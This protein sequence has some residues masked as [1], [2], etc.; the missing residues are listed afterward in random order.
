MGLPRHIHIDTALEEE[1]VVRSALESAT[2]T[3]LSDE[4]LARLH[5]VLY[6]VFCVTYS[7]ADDGF[8]VRN[9]TGN[10]DTILVDGLWT[11][12]D[13]E[14]APYTEAASDPQRV[15]VRDYD[16]GL[17]HDGPGTTVALD[18]QTTN[19]HAGS[20]LPDRVERYCADN[21][22]GEG[23]AAELKR[24]FDFPQDIDFDSFEDVVS[25]TRTYLPFWL[26]EFH[27]GDE[28][29]ATLR[30]FRTLE[31]IRDNS[32]R[33]QWLAAFISEDP[34]RLATYGHRIASADASE[35]LDDQSHR[36]TSTERTESAEGPERSADDQPQSS[37]DSS[38]EREEDASDDSGP[39]QPEGAELQADQLLE[40][41]PERGF[42][43]VGGMDDL[44]DALEQKVIDPLERPEAY[45]EYGIGTVTGV[46]L[47][48]PPGCG[49][50]YI[51]GALAGEIGYNVVELDPADLT[52]RYMGQ[53]AKNVEDAFAVARANQPCVVFIDEIDAIAGSRDGEMNTSE[54]QMVNQLLTELEAV[55][56]ED[57]VVIAATN[58]VEDI[59]DAIRRSGRFDERIEVPPPGADARREI[60][61]LYLDERPVVD[62]IDLDEVVSKTAGYAAS[63][64]EHL[65]NEAARK[66][67]HD[68]EDIAAE[69][70]LAA[71]EENTTSIPDWTGE[72][73]T[74]VLDITEPSGVDLNAHHLLEPNPDRD[75]ADVGGMGDL[76]DTLRE[77]VIH[78]LENAEDYAEY[79][80]GVTDGVLLH[81][82]PGCGKTYVAGA[83]AGELGHAF[84]PVS[85]ADVTSKWM[86]RPAKNV[87]DL[88]TIARA[89]AP[90]VLFID[91]IDAIAGSRGGEM[92]TSEQQMVNQLLTELEG[93][94][95]DGV[96]V[97]AAT[98]LIEDVDDAILRSGRFDERIE[99]PAPDE[100]ARR[101]ILELH[102][103][104]RP[105]AEDIEWDAIVWKTAGYAASDLA[106][107]AEHA[108]REALREGSVV[109]TDHL[110]EAVQSTESSIEQWV[111][112]DAENGGT[113][114]SEDS[115]AGNRYIR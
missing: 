30:S 17:N 83:L 54:Q 25:V 70:L 63:D 12:N 60:L 89:N 93:S 34:A 50:T 105:F 88:F 15:D 5:R 79:G 61:H 56:E 22:Y 19:D 64:V 101:A 27:S 28:Q 20:L 113:D 69:H 97:L 82:P 99:V 52:S 9:A 109:D 110:L 66:A 81:G 75:F 80:L 4:R 57:V 31:D 86:G 40:P 90:C 45:A 107:L 18:F 53:P 76:K 87:A 115:L 58:L 95:E 32:H 72:V 114:D 73:G 23:Y 29:S 103:Q 1:S 16:L 46:L 112:A 108:A 24:T 94:G 100:D 7:Y 104:D 14:I 67:L 85:P 91:E 44:K 59:D 96:V 111:A 10:T 102:L 68:G 11:G 37:E 49:K 78:P 98:N 39:V 13:A 51:A 43:D 92:N 41:A 8:L 36:E 3:P 47:H 26:A 71:L 48:G 2:V 42:G 84:L 65:A 62:D 6:P 106:L 55:A 33:H 74:E 77:T 38:D 35:E 21:A